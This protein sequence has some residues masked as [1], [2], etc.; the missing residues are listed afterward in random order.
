RAA[1]DTLTGELGNLAHQ[2]VHISSRLEELAILSPAEGQA[3]SYCLVFRLLA[4]FSQPVAGPLLHPRQGKGEAGLN[5]FEG[6]GCGH[7]ERVAEPLLCRRRRI[8]WYGTRQR[9]TESGTES[10]E[11]DTEL[12]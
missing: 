10:L 12:P 8:H 7:P 1:A 9:G 6:G 3:F 2:G 11:T 5:V 4:Q